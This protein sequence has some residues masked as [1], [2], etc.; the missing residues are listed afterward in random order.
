M[1]NQIKSACYEPRN[2]CAMTKYGCVQK[3]RENDK[4]GKT[5]HNWK[6]RAYLLRHFCNGTNYRSTA[7]LQKWHSGG[8]A[9]Y[10]TS[11]ANNRS[12]IA[13]MLCHFYNVQTK[14][15]HLLIATR[16]AFCISNTPNA[17]WSQKLRIKMTLQ[18]STAHCCAIFKNF[19]CHFLNL[20]RMKLARQITK[21]AL[22]YRL[23]DFLCHFLRFASCF[24]S[25]G[26][27]RSGH[28]V[29]KYILR[30]NTLPEPNLDV[31]LCIMRIAHANRT[32]FQ[33]FCDFY[34]LLQSDPV[35]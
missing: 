7:N 28:V 32:P 1:C 14:N 9:Y 31:C 2:E 15:L 22:L 24:A 33:S 35:N 4:K 10:R 25:F 30:I 13:T 12:S 34:V 29:M 3:W 21:A 19:F 16:W 23:C 26:T 5:N 20:N 8:I 18:M 27:S 11:M 17:I 6:T